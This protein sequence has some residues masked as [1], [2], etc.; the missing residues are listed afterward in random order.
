MKKA[1]FTL[2]FSV[3]LLSAFSQD[4]PKVSK[5]FYTELGGPG[6]MFSANMDTRLSNKSHLGWG[7]R[8]GIGFTIKDDDYY[9]SNG[10]YSSSIRTIPTLPVGF[11]YLFGKEGSAHTFE[12][13]AG[14]TFLFQ[15]VE[16]L[17]YDS[18]R[19]EGYF[20]GFFTF[21]YRRQP[22]TDG[23]TWRIGMTPLINTAGDI[24][25]FGAAGIGFA[26]R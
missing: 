6:I 2:L 23:F 11:N 1:F 7:L 12:V 17:N 8:V 5:Q 10:N 16:M 22:L 9:D 4:E 21:M 13:G 14:T 3:F 18:H 24:V 20:M 26:F 15:K 19:K 25:P